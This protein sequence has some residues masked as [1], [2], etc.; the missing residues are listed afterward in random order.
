MYVFSGMGNVL[1]CEVAGKKCSKD[2]D[3]SFVTLSAGR[4]PNTGGRGLYSSAP[5]NSS[6]TTKSCVSVLAPHVSSL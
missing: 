4:G 1:G 5:E 2:N 6:A 3:H